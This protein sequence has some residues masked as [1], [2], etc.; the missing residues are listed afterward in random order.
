MTRPLPDGFRPDRSVPFVDTVY[1]AIAGK[2]SIGDVATQLTAIEHRHRVFLRP[3]VDLDGP[4]IPVGEQEAWIEQH[5]YPF[6]DETHLVIAGGDWRNDID[7]R[8]ERG[9]E[10]G[11]SFRG[12]G[13]IVA[14]WANSRGWPAGAPAR[15]WSYGDFHLGGP[16]MLG[17]DDFVRVVLQAIH[18][19]ARASDDR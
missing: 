5:L 9:R 4:L 2:N 15:T 11:A 13:G 10:L 7:I 19:R 6:L 12:W 1:Q 18:L 8:D 14:S 16:P 17:Y 3:N